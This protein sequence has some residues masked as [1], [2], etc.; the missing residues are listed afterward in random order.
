[1]TLE[2]DHV[3]WQQRMKQRL[4]EQRQELVEAYERKLLLV[5]KNGKS[6]WKEVDLRDK[7]LEVESER[8]KTAELKVGELEKLLEMRDAT[9]RELTSYN[10]ELRT[11]NGSLRE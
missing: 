5:E 1:M 4:A 9:I 11:Q 2:A 10:D 3:N 6:L 8:R 7:E